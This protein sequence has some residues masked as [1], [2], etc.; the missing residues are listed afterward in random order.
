MKEV[1]QSESSK[2]IER[3]FRRQILKSEAYTP[4]VPPGVLSEEIG[5]SVEGI[6]KLDGN[7][8]PYGC[9]PRVQLALA[10]HSFYHIYPD[11]E[12]RD[13]REALAQ[14]VNIDSK[15]IVAGSGSDELIDLVLRLFIE[16]GDRV[17][18]C[19]PT[20]GMYPFSTEVCGGKVVNVPRGKGFAIDVAK[21]KAAVDT[22][23]KIIFIASPNN[24]TGN[25]TPQKDILELLETGSVVVVDEAYCEFSGKTVVELVPHHDNLVV[26]RTFSKWAGLAGLRVGYGIFPTHVARYITKIKIPYNVNIAAQI[27]AIESLNDLA[28]LKS[29][30]QSIVKERDRLFAKLQKFQFLHPLPS[31]ANFI[32]C[33]ISKGK[34]RDIH[35]YLQQKGIFLRHF[36]TPALQDCLRI[37]V[38][39]PEQNDILL[40]TL[41]E[42]DRDRPLKTSY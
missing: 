19:T 2:G 40:K 17:I 25:V 29:I 26:L 6:I 30:V 37:S 35:S 33:S 1:S 39:K 38:G 23:T 41:E 12:Q 9:S 13:L 10:D 24:P 8:N 16:P 20:F 34:A 11:P 3:L 15:Y 36:D 22:C 4:I 5:V 7:E 31:E 18:N 27:A 28:H 21:I 14:Y 42:I 32:L